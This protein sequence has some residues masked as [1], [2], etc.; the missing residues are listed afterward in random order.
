MLQS[1]LKAKQSLYIHRN[2]KV[3]KPTL[4]EMKVYIGLGNALPKS[5]LYPD[6]ADS[7]TWL[8]TKVYTTNKKESQKTNLFVN[9][10]SE[11][12]Q[13]SFLRDLMMCIN[14]ISISTKDEGVFY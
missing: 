14:R 11:D 9:M 13:K 10:A 8:K 7:A 4:N 6:A 5:V 1:S 12:S 2:S 3:G